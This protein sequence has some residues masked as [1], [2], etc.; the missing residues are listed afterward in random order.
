MT[1]ELASF[2]Y[3]NLPLR[4]TDEVRLVKICRGPGEN[5]TDMIECH[6]EVARL[7]ATPEYAALSYTWGPPTREDESRGMTADALY[8]IKC[9]GQVVL[10]AANLFSFLRRLRDG[11]WFSDALIFRPNGLPEWIW[12]DAICINQ[13]DDIERASQVRIMYR[14]YQ[15]ARLVMMWLGEED[16]ET[17]VALALIQK[18]VFCSLGAWRSIHPRSLD[19][20][21]DLV[22]DDGVHLASWDAMLRLFQ[23]N[24]FTRMWIVQEVVQAEN[25]WIVCGHH[26]LQFQKL[27]KVAWHLSSS[28]PWTRY[29]NSR[30]QIPTLSPRQPAANSPKLLSPIQAPKFTDY[31]LTL[32]AMRQISLS[33]E[34]NPAQLLLQMLRQFRCLQAGDPRDK[35]YAL[36]GII[37]SRFEDARW[38]LLAD[39]S[40]QDSYVSSSIWLLQPVYGSHTPRDVYVECAIRILESVQDLRL[41]SCVEGPEFQHL[42]GL[43][44]WVPDWSV[45][46]RVGLGR[47]SGRFSAA[48]QTPRSLVVDPVRIMLETQGWKLDTI[49]CVGEPKTKILENKPFPQ[50]LRILHDLPVEYPH[51]RG[52]LTTDAFALAMASL[53]SEQYTEASKRGNHIEV[54]TWLL[55]KL[56]S[57]ARRVAE[58]GE[59]EAEW[60][61][62]T[63]LMD[64]L[65]EKYCGE[66]PSTLDV[67]TY[68][69]EGNLVWPIFCGGRINMDA[70]DEYDTLIART[71]HLRLFRTE[72]DCIGLGSESCTEGDTVWIVPGSDV[73]LIFRKIKGEESGTGTGEDHALVGGA[74]VHGFMNGEAFSPGNMTLGELQLETLNII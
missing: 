69:N 51:T 15:Q 58:T 9:N 18:I 47:A 50:W 3:K 20:C 13:Q 19:S 40:S 61:E 41:L 74:Y 39:S 44:S 71:P 16:L 68:L 22:G 67:M 24:Y 54:S 55:L 26:M 53:S 25:A 49:T 31:H 33:F 34:P 43:P 66:F 36:L 52:E 72:K 8:P 60:R 21:R 5:L 11:K 56:A 73:P 12:I 70:V 38:K 17:D 32:L 37:R 46:L 64:K 14:I 45:S 2:N 57:V 30:V 48:G 65:A 23:R 7:S 29:L 63:A 27:Q 6:V 1:L 4:S 35:V 10:V 42:A 28:A 62:Q 59:G